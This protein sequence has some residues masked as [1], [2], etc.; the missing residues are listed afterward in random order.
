MPFIAEGVF[1]KVLYPRFILFYFPYV[2]ILIAAIIEKIKDSKL[3]YQKYI[4]LI[5]SVFFL[6]PAFNSFL[7][8]T[9]PAQAKIADSDKGQYLNDWPAGYGVKEAVDLIK[10]TKNTQPVYV[11]TEG[12]FGLLPYAIQIYFFA[13]PQVQIIGYW[14]VDSEKIPSEVLDA[15][16]NNKVYFIFNENQKEITNPQLKFINKFQKGTGKSY[17]RIYEV[18]PE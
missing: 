1:N 17:L 12:T 5:L 8:L 18:I 3:R 10:N 2:I 6:F 4:N 9:N 7:L 15:T 13:D 16:K 14:P 11:A